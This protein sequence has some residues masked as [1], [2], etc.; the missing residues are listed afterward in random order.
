MTKR[1]PWADKAGKSADQRGYG[2]AH[3]AMRAHLMATVILCE[4]CTAKGRST[5]GTIA[6]HRIPKARGGTDDRENYSLLCVPCHDAKSLRE[7]GF[8]VRPATGADGWPIDG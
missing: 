8:K 2:R 1:T 7:R 6:D 4:H 5:P 3:R